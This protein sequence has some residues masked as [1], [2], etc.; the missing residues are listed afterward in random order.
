[1]T[2]IKRETSYI[3]RWKLPKKKSSISNNQQKNNYYLDLFIVLTLT[4]IFSLSMGYFLGRKN[5]NFTHSKELDKFISDYNYIKENY[6]DEIDEKKVFKKALSSIVDELGDP[7]SSVVSDTLSNSLN[8]QLNGSYSGFGIEI[9][10][11]ESGEIAILGVVENSPAERAGL[12]PG[13][14]IVKFE[15]EDLKNKT[16]TD[17]T[18]MVKN[19]KQQEI[20]LL[21]KRD[22]IDKTF[23]IKREI[24][25][26]KSVDGEILSKDNKK[27]AYIYIS[28]FAANTDKQFKDILDN[29]EKKGFDS[30]IIDVRD[31][32]GGHLTSVE[33]I[34]SMFLDNNHV[35]YQMQ[36]KKETKKY[37]SKGKETKKYPVAVLVNKNSASAS[38]MLTA[39]LKEEYKANIVG[40]KTYGKGTVQEVQN[41]QNTD[42]KYKLTTKKWLTPKGNW[43]N[44]KGIE[45]NIKVELDKNYYKNP[46]KQNDNQLQ[47]AIEINMN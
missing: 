35:I 45:P 27:I 46:T 16:T 38:E 14:I 8:T 26:L 43:I 15:N 19:S 1:M 2:R 34:I 6:Y 37:Y 47:K 24:V 22:N 31:N 10:N 42:I 23:S 18:N 32:T 13:D 11:L 40:D 30:L 25:T 9:V 29:L 33:N 44:S 17:F 21:I 4:V 28:I 7:Y 3:K 41:S 20:K 39:A 36:T 12:K 5:S